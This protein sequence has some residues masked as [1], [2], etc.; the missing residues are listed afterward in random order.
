MNRMNAS[1]KGAAAGPAEVPTEF[2]NRPGWGLRALSR[3]GREPALAITACYVFVG[4]VGVWSSYWYYGALGIP[5]LEYYQVSDFL[6]AG[7]RDPYNFL[8]LLGVLALALLSYS[9]AWYEL[10]NPGHVE[11]LRRRWWWR[12]WFNRWSSP[13]RP[14]R[15][16]D[17]PPESI[18]L[19]LVFVSGGSLMVDHATSR[20]E[21]LRAG[22]GHPLRVTLQG[23]HL[24]L[25]GEARLAGTSSTHVFLVWP[26][27]GRVEA[28]PAQ[29]VARIEHLPRV[30]PAVPGAGA[31]K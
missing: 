27:N 6:I 22:G 19:L 21:T 28:L 11:R 4:A 23:A 1:T 20:A 12:I 3:I 17:L 13:H 10:R 24:P 15:W 16:Y 31:A 8:A 7:L 9:S 2:A 25:Q 14:R 26:A 5:I 30:R 29:S 18:V